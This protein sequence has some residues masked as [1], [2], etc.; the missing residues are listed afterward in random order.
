MA[1]KSACSKT[2]LKV[3]ALAFAIHIGVMFLFPLCRVNNTELHL[4]LADGS[5]EKRRYV[6]WLPVYTKVLSTSFSEVLE[7][8]EENE[9]PRT[10]EVWRGSWW[11]RS[12][13]SLGPV[14]PQIAELGLIWNEE[15]APK[16][17]RMS[18]AKYLLSQWSLGSRE[19][20]MRAEKFIE[21]KKSALDP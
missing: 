21:G 9:N 2:A 18:E 14:A 11:H 5:L 7:T 17:K 15:N 13:R 3:F 12:I 10:V 1:G 19:S 4:N 16:S 20:L 8:E 6:L